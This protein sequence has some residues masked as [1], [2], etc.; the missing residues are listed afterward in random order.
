V[1]IGVESIAGDHTSKAR[2]HTTVIV[3]IV[4][5]LIIIGFSLI[6]YVIIY[7]PQAFSEAFDPFP[8]H[9]W[10]HTNVRGEVTTEGFIDLPVPA[11][12]EVLGNAS[13]WKCVVVLSKAGNLTALWS[14]GPHFENMTEQQLAQLSGPSLDATIVRLGYGE[15]G[16]AICHLSH[17]GDEKW[18]VF[19]RDANLWN[20]S[21][22]P[23]TII[24]PAR[25]GI[26]VETTP[27]H[28]PARNEDTAWDTITIGSVDVVVGM[29][30]WTSGDNERPHAPSIIYRRDGEGWS[31]IVVIDNV[32][33]EHQRIAGTSL[34]D[35][36]I[37]GIDH[38]DHW[39]MIS[40][41]DNMV[42]RAGDAPPRHGLP[43]D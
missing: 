7:G 23:V 39:W 18:W 43:R 38:R 10:Q 4:V 34:D 32:M 31:T 8:Y 30:I 20:I 19:E 9:A 5:A 24:G 40:V 15:H 28:R 36:V 12:Y 22:M 25:P 37:V 16:E 26:D 6:A 27:H 33:M 1:D 17:K 3:A 21:T 42:T 2:F 14:D 11:T 41:N 35:M 13:G 29:Y